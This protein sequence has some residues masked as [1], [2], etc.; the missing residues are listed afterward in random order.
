MSLKAAIRSI[1]RLSLFG[2]TAA[3]HPSGEARLPASAHAALTASLDSC[4]AIRSRTAVRESPTLRTSSWSTG[5][6]REFRGF[7]LFVPDSARVEPSDSV[8]G[9]VRLSWSGC[10][11]CGLIVR[12]EEDSSGAGIDGRVARLMAAQRVIDSINNDPH[13]T[14]FEFDELDGPPRP[15]KTATQRG[16]MLE[17]SC[18]DCGSETMLFGRRGQI[19][20]VSLSADDDEP[21]GPR[22]MCELAVVGKTFRWRE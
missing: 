7:A 9:D 2:L 20:V 13:T 1:A 21:A 8:A 16:I 15:F 5:L 12:L 14:V 6:V 3:C 19:A 10:A 4:R 22:R 17:D 18:G 11:S